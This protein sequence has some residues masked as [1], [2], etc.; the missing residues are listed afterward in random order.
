MAKSK[1]QRQPPKKS[2]STTPAFDTTHAVEA[3]AAMI[4]GGRAPAAGK[5][6]PRKQSLEFQHLKEG[7]S[8]P[9]LQGL[10][11]ILDTTGSPSSKK[12]SVPFEHGGHKQ[13]GHNQTSGGNVTRSGVPRRTAG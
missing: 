1:P 3:A 12:S 11:K 2:D 7:I 9:G 8:Q 4:A 6:T 10:D 5:P 13:V